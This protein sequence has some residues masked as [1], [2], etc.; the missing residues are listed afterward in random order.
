M[1]WMVEDLIL[2]GWEFHK[3]ETLR[4]KQLKATNFLKGG[5][6]TFWLWCKRVKNKFIE[7]SDTTGRNG[8]VHLIKN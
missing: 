6:W 8:A 7:Q 1:E 5:L 3:L 4:I 2:S